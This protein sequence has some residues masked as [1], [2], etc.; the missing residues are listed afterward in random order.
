MGN[1]ATVVKEIVEEQKSKIIEIV[2]RK[3][4]ICTHCVGYHKRE[5]R[6]GETIVLDEEKDMIMRS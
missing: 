4:C 5:P 6:L 1:K 3:S 2:R